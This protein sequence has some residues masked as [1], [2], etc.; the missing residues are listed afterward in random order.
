VTGLRDF[1]DDW[2]FEFLTPDSEVRREV[3]FLPMRADCYLA[4][5]AEEVPSDCVIVV[6]AT[7]EHYLQKCAAAICTHEEWARAQG[8]GYVRQTL[9]FENNDYKPIGT[10]P[11]MDP[12]IVDLGS[13]RSQLARAMLAYLGSASG[14][15]RRIWLLIIETDSWVTDM[16]RSLSDIIAAYPSSVEMIVPHNP[17]GPLGMI[18]VAS[19]NVSEYYRPTFMDNAILL[20]STPN[21]VRLF[22]KWVSLHSV[23]SNKRCGGLGGLVLNEAVLHEM[24]RLDGAPAY[25]SECALK[26]TPAANPYV[27]EPFACVAEWFWTYKKAGFDHTRCLPWLRIQGPQPPA[28]AQ[29]PWLMWD[30]LDNYHWVDLTPPSHG[31]Q[32]KSSAISM[33]WLNTW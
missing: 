11:V 17:F 26:C 18:P 1:L 28:H 24:A 20:R 5:N 23:I 31:V 8:Y 3:R 30:W 29:E 19:L 12:Q 9:W 16:R 22:N 33:A 7:E 32:A 15:D 25:H 27:D 10:G 14:A 21:T 4:L 13:Q 6:E 2:P